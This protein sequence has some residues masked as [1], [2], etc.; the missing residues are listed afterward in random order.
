[1]D[2]LA[3]LYE[4]HGAFFGWVAAASLLMFVVS[5][6]SLPWLVAR[7]PEDY[8]QSPEPY[9]HTH[10]FRH[11]VMRLVIL[12]IK[13]LLGGVLMLAGL[14]LLL[15]PGQGVLT[16]L[17]ALVLLDFPGKRRFE[18]WLIAKPAVFKTM[19]WLRR[20]AGHGPLRAPE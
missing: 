1:M 6:A 4:T 20:R 3:T 8:F 13:N 2:K 18:R 19:N 11:P 7:L 9:A 14:V 15:L 16:I 17:M 10:E 5:L 12:V